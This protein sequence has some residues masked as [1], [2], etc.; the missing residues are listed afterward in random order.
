MLWAIEGQVGGRRKKWVVQMQQNAHER[1]ADLGFNGE[2][3]A[4]V[5]HRVRL[6]EQ[7]RSG[8]EQGLC[9]ATE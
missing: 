7:V 8:D 6:G 5:G 3:F 1:V 2:R 4:D 9:Q